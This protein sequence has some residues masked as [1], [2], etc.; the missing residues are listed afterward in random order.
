MFGRRKAV[1]AAAVIA[2]LVGILAVPALVQAA[3]SEPHPVA[4]VSLTIDGYEL[5]SFSR[6]IGLGSESTVEP[7]PASDDEIIFKNLP[8]ETTGR[9]VCERGLTSSIQLAAWRDAVVLGDM[10]AARKSV[11]ITMYDTAGDPQFRWHLTDAWPSG[12]TNL[13]DQDG[14]GREVVTFTYE[15][16]Q[17]VS[18]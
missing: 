16:A 13:F 1:V 18:V 10:A 2:P 14:M 7:A 17:R 3:I 8:G 5:A 6:C 12:L 4:R 9:T 11:S 15:F